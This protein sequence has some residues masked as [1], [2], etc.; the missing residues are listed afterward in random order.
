LAAFPS[1]EAA[2]QFLGE[3][4][5]YWVS[6]EG[7]QMDGEGPIEDDQG[8]QIGSIVVL[9][10]EIEG[11]PAEVVVWQIDNLEA[12][13]IGPQDSE[14]LLGFISELEYGFTLE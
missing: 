13:A 12:S 6:V 4:V 11:T 2:N 14:L 9:Q 3:D 5:D 10:G 1:P 8:N 7:F